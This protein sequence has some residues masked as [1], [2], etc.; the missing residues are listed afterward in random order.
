MNTNDNQI[1]YLMTI[2]NAAAYYGI[3]Q[4]RLRFLAQKMGGEISVTSGNRLLI[5]RTELEAYIRT[6]NNIEGGTQ[7][8]ILR[9]SSPST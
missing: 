7:I 1:P 4:K 9:T 5:K 3:G 2:K 8:W 6:A